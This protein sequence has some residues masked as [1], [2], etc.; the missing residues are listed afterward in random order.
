M[1]WLLRYIQTHR[2]TIFAWYRIALGVA[3][4]AWLALAPGAL[5]GA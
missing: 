2:F 4:L 3:L 5:P 1:K